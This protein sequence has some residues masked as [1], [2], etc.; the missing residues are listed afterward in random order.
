MNKKSPF[1]KGFQILPA[2]RKDREPEGPRSPGGEDTGNYR[3]ATMV[4]AIVMVV[5]RIALR[6]AGVQMLPVR[7]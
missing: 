6:K 5:I 2:E 4:F 3:R 7:L 1:G